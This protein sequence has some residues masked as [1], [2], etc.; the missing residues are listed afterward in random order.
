MSPEP[1]HD[2]GF[3]RYVRDEHG[4]AIDGPHFDP[5]FLAYCVSR[6]GSSPGHS[7]GSAAGNW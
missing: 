7:T 3:R 6:A 1:D 4:N 5:E 2:D